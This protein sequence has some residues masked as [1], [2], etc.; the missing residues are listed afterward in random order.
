MN[1]A[2]LAGVKGTSLLQVYSDPRIR[3]KLPKGTHP[4]LHLDI[5]NPGDWLYDTRYTCICSVCKQHYFGPK[6]SGTCWEHT[7][8]VLKTHWVGSFQEPINPPMDIPSA[9]LP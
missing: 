9:Q 1:V 7:S 2:D 4:M 5:Q 8:E 6:R 3:M